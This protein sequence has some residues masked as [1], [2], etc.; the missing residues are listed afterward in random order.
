AIE[1]GQTLVENQ[2]VSYVPEQGPKG[3]QATKVQAL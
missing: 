3:P 1:A 2:R